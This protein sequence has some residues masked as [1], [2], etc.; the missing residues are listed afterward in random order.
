MMAS[1]DIDWKNSAEKDLR[2]I[3]NRYIKRILR[4]VENLSNNPF[5]SKLRKIQGTDTFFRV[6][7]GIYRV[8]YQIDMDNDLVII[9]HVRHRRDAY[10]R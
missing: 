2:N 4:V 8:I 1:Y 9:H 10:R 7:V 6:R 3:D 5:P